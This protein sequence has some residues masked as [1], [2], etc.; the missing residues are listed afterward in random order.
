MAEKEILTWSDVDALMDHLIPQF[1]GTFDAL[2]I[3]TRGGIV[4]GG[5]LSEV[6]DIRYVLTASVKFY[7]GVEKRMAWPSFLQF[8]SDDLLRG[9]RVL[10]IDDIWDSG[11]TINAVKGRVEAAG[12][13][14]ELA[15][16]HYKPSQSLFPDSKP[17]YF[18]AVTDNWVVYPWELGYG[19]DR[20][21]AHPKGQ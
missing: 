1:R 14:P 10:V 21:L 9:K 8:P 4:P 3:I 18:A 20:I 2:L 6:L 11:R 19:T 5:I 12:G 15:V 17:D 16:L 7:T 13:K